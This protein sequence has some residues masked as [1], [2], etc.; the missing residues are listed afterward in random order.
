MAQTVTVQIQSENGSRRTHEYY[1]EDSATL[2]EIQTTMDS[3]LSALDLAIEG[4]I[5][6]VSLV[7]PLTIPGVVKSTPNA[8]A[9]HDNA[10]RFVF[11]TAN[12]YTTTKTV[13]TVADSQFDFTANPINPNG[14][15]IVVWHDRVV[16]NTEPSTV[17]TTDYRGD[18]ISALKSKR[19]F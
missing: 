13:T 1:F 19:G 6:G 2:T 3:L 7:T 11:N 8:G 12:G 4:A 16:N 15:S 14:A 17:Q 5:V 10:A 9:N 18:D